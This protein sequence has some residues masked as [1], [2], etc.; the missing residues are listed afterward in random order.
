MIE[1]YLR[2]SSTSFTTALGCN[3]KI[4]GWVKQLGLILWELIPNTMF[5]VPNPRP[6]TG[7]PKLK[8]I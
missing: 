5:H 3:A 8:N 7:D 6:N 2:E 4:W 1:V